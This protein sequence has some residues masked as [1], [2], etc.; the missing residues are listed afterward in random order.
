[1]GDEMPSSLRTFYEPQ[2]EQLGV[3]L[4]PCP[5]G[6]AGSVE[7]DDARAW[8]WVAALGDACLLSAHAVEPAKPMLLEERP[9]DYGCITS[10]S[11]ATARECA[12]GVAPRRLAETGNVLAFAQSA[13]TVTCLLQPKRRYEARNICL[14]PRFF[15]EL[16][17]CYGAS[18]AGMMERF[19]KLD[20]DLLPAELRTLLDSIGPECAMRPGAPLLM[21]ARVDE[22]VYL[23]AESMEECRRARQ[24]K[25]AVCQRSL[26]RRACG[27][28]DAD[29]A[30]VPLLDDLAHAVYT[31]RAHLCAAF[32]QEMGVSVGAYVRR[33]R[34]ERAGDLLAR[35][36]LPVA[37]VAWQVGY[38]NPGSFAEA[39]KRETG[40]S[41][42]TWR[43]M[44]RGR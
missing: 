4:S 42:R 22:A 13:G 8:L 3:R 30:N 28:I 12:P 21:R 35:T 36:D 39:F 1:M 15:D 5:Y 41:P 19:D 33:R 25:G 23:L 34:M 10:A 37:S 17:R 2:A 43:R 29:L 27:I 6:F 31:S 26:V 16:A 7:N 11:A 32:K 44:K 20:P 9:L 18:F 14:L 40:A 24:E 38:S